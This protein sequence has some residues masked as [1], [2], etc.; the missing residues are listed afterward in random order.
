MGMGAA[1]GKGVSDILSK[2][3]DV[4][5]GAAVRAFRETP[6]RLLSKISM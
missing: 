3:T 2:L 1:V 5:M 4:G 6:L